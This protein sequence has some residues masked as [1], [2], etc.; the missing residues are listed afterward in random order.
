MN[1]KK[2]AKISR[3]NM[4]FIVFAVFC[5]LCI[6]GNLIL[7]VMS[8]GDSLAQTLF[9]NSSVNY[10]QDFFMD[11]FNSIRDAG[12]LDVYTKGVIYPPLANL[13]FLFFSKFIQSSLVN[14][15]FDFR[16][17]FQSNQ[18]AIVIYLI[19][20]MLCVV[21]LSVI[22][23]YYLKDKNTA[24]KAELLSFVFI[25]FYPTYY[26]LERGNILILSMIFTAFFVFF[27]DSKNRAVREY[28]LI[29]LAVAAGLKL[30]PALFGLILLNEK[31][32]KEA[33]KAIIYGIVFFLLPFVA[34]GFNDGLLLFF[35][36]IFAFS[37]EN[38]SAFVFGSTSIVN[39][40]YYFGDKFI[41]IGKILFVATEVIAAVCV[42]IAPK[43]WQKYLLMT[44]M[45][46]NIQ[47]VSSTYAL[48]F[49]IIPFVVFMSDKNK[50]RKSDWI[51]LILFCLLLLPLPCVY[52]FDANIIG[53][54]RAIF[55]INS[56]YSV[57]KL[58]ALPV[59]QL[60]F[61][62]VCVESLKN[63][64]YQIKK[65]KKIPEIFSAEKTKKT[66]KKAQ[67]V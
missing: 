46:V 65:G 51:Y 17:A 38:K 24:L 59:T 29:F 20:A 49:M 36:N 35:K 44:Y 6:I 57:N 8:H 18:R 13:I 25:I 27:H 52:F 33:L 3:S 39:A 21:S 19:F 10:N 48:I 45:L 7:A 22:I 37:S 1:K 43:K 23:K 67:E 31:R 28:A 62:L 40:A 32:Y 16:Y 4:F 55:K 64:V 63:F 9:R 61:M 54:V 14:T 42:F 60:M 30:Y 50:K 26:C 34:Y 15:P 53:Y 5:G 58:I 2:S 41:N 12:S 47:S 66:V 56:V 11:F